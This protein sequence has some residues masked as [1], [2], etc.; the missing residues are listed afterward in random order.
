MLPRGLCCAH[1]RDSYRPFTRVIRPS[2]SSAAPGAAVVSVMAGMGSDW[3]QGRRGGGME[4][5]RRKTDRDVAG[6]NEEADCDPWVSQRRSTW[7]WSGSWMRW[8]GW[9]RVGSKW[10]GW[11]VGLLL[12]FTVGC[13]RWFVRCMSIHMIFF[14][15]QGRFKL[16]TKTGKKSLPVLTPPTP[17]THPTSC[18][19]NPEVNM[20]LF[21]WSSGR[22]FL[23]LI[24]FNS[25]THRWT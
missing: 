22:Y 21:L 15:C 6:L 19:E 25:I 7:A 17:T 16:F 4:G 10:E 24:W 11:T 3:A 1:G 2:N 8:A 14:F 23:S 13:S 18:H 5:R 12:T 9:H 20:D